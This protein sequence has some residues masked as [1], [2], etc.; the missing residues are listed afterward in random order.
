MLRRILS[1]GL[2]IVAVSAVVVATS[3]T[4]ATTSFRFPV[5]ILATDCPDPVALTGTL[6]GVITTVDNGAGGVLVSTNFNPQGV[7]GVGLVSGRIYHGT[8]VTH[9][10]FRAAKGE[11]ETFVNNF[12]L[13][14]PGP[15]GDVIV[16]E[17]FHVTVNANGTVTASADPSPPTARRRRAVPVAEVGVFP[18]GCTPPGASCVRSPAN[19][20]RH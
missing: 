10:T 8:G 20:G 1:F 14:S 15:G 13:I 11:T 6:H 12:R 3:A 16:H 5:N 9:D 19:W 2:P 17:L 4:A 7:T 18:S